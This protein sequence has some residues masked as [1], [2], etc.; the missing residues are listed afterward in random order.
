M[1]ALLSA[2]LLAFASPSPDQVP[3]E[4]DVR[5]YRLMAQLARDEDPS[6]RSLAV[7]AAHFFLGRIDS[8]APDFDVQSLPDVAEAERPALIVSCGESLGEAGFDP[9]ALR[10]SPAAQS[11]SI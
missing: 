11:L 2:G 7:T 5:C 10:E 3:A 4:R 1:I 9:R 8:A 6:V